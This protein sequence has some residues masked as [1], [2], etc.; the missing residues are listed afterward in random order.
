MQTKLLL[1]FACILY[2]SLNNCMKKVC[3]CTFQQF[4][5]AILANHCKMNIVN[6]HYKRG[7]TIR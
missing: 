4:Y 6:C 5:N 2:Y 7:S 1:N 3:S